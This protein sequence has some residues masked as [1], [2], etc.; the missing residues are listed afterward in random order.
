ML[1]VVIFFNSTQMLPI[2]QGADRYSYSNKFQVRVE[3]S[4][5]KEKRVSTQLELKRKS[6]TCCGPSQ[7]NFKAQN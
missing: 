7:P 1:W 3:I 2:F 6:H 4:L 5:V